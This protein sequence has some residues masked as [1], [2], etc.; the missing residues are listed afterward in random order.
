MNSEK[1]L[2]DV[3]NELFNVSMPLPQQDEFGDNYL[4]IP[5]IYVSRVSMPLPQQ[6]EFGESMALNSKMLTHS[7]LNAA[8]AAR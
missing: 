6:D 7:S 5:I 2:F 4:F 8:S 1:R 3:F